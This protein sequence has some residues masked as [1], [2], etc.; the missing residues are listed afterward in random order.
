[1]PLNSFYPRPDS[2]DR[3]SHQ[4]RLPPKG[5]GA[6]L[7]EAAVGVGIAP[8]APRPEESQP[9][10]EERFVHPCLVYVPCREEKG[11][12]WEYFHQLDVQ[13]TLEHNLRQ[14][15]A[16]STIARQMLIARLQGMKQRQV[17]SGFDY[18]AHFN[19]ADK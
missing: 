5:T 6:D 14:E 8:W 1:M 10:L 17:L 2:I 9:S 3:S 15:E 19:R 4:K 11:D 13:K 18:A 7:E 16:G 12:R